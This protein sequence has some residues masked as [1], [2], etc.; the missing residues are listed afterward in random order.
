M[1]IDP[2]YVHHRLLFITWL[3][4]ALI[5][6]DGGNALIPWDFKG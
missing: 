1:H 4:L 2:K 5:L 3:V 6:L